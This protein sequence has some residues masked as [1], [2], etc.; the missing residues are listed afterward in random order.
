[1]KLQSL[2]QNSHKEYLY[3][4]FFFGGWEVLGGPLSPVS[5]AAAGGSSGSGPKMQSQVLIRISSSPVDSNQPRNVE[6]FETLHEKYC[7]TLKIRKKIKIASEKFQCESLALY[8]I[9]I[10]SHEPQF[11]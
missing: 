7:K 3:N 2:C 9:S 10:L 1:M 6:L 8:F 4:Y 11:M 5:R